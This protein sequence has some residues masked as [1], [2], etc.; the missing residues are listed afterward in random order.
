MLLLFVISTI[1]CATNCGSGYLFVITNSLVPSKVDNNFWFPAHIYFVIKTKY[2]PGLLA[3]FF[4][5]Y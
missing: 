3:T 5:F 4:S 1:M 2:E